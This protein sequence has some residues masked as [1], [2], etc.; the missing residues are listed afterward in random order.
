MLK[1]IRITDKAGARL[2]ISDE[3][4]RDSKGGYKVTK[5]GREIHSA[6]LAETIM[7]PDEIWVGTALVPIPA[8]Q[9]GG[10]ET[11]IDRKFIRVD[12]KTGLLAVF[13]LLKGRWT[14]KTAFRPTNKN[15][16][17]TSV[18]AIDKRRAGVLVY[19]RK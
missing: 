13:E 16:T 19:S 2:P 17:T 7:D 4:F 10:Y 14:A 12:P 6:Q 9:G 5:R 1:Y 18:N 11:V 3:L 8:D 15:S